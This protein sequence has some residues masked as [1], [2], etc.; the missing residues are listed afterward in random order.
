MG[1]LSKIKQKLLPGDLHARIE[2]KINQLSNP[3][4]ELGYDEWGMHLSSIKKAI[5]SLSF[6]Y[7]KYFRV[8]THGIEKVPPGRVLLVANHGGQLP[9]DAA[10]L[11]Y[12]MFMYANPPRVARTMADR[13]LPRMPFLS[14][15][16]VRCGQVIGTPLNC[17]ALLEKEE[18]VIVFPEGTRGL[19]K[20]YWKRY[21][22]QEFGTGF[23]RIALETNTPIVPIAFIGSEEAYPSF[24]NAKSLAKFF[25]I[26]YFPITPT[27]PILGPV[28]A[29]PIPAKLHIHFGDPMTFSGDF[30][31]TEQEIHQKAT[32]VSQNIQD[33]IKQGLRERKKIFG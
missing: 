14:T 20:P 8:E 24:Y 31:G 33:M 17:K 19:G 9:I 27:W 2:E 12:A 3:L 29:L 23:M 13:F 26:P 18:A 32:L 21:Q 25:K 15:F 30:D 7:E 28:G 11:C 4:N 22:I 6:L 5:L 10:M 16:F 1:I